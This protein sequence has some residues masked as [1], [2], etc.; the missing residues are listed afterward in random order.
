MQVQRVSRHKTPT[1]MTVGEIFE[2]LERLHAKFAE[3]VNA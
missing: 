3:L 1:Q 2:E